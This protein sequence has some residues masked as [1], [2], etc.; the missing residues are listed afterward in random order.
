MAFLDPVFNPVL[1]PLLNVSP[2]LVIVLVSLL[3]SL[4][5]TF[6]YKWMTN[7]DEMKRLKEQQKEYQ[8]RMK[9]LRS[10]PDEMMKVQKEAM[11]ANMD[12]MK[13]SFKPT[14]V[15]MLPIIL[16][17]TW[18]AG[19]LSYEPVYPGETYS[20]TATF[21]KGVTGTAE[22][23]ADVGTEL[24]SEAK[25]QVN[26]GEVTW[27]MKSAEGEHTLT[28]K[29]GETQQQKKVLITKDLKYES[30]LSEFK[31]SAI[32]K[33]TINYNKL[34]PLGQLSL[35]GWQPGWLGI[36][37]IFSIVFSLGLRKLLKIY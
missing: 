13:Q 26:N 27:R 2:A 15:T 36:Y 32:E 3:V 25:Q 8:K 30:Q 6:V 23:V 17:F 12:Y 9:G 35:F 21:A 18:M 20:I 4:L 14:L 5:I 10:N 28:V 33:I 22:L 16:I 1:Q 31:N 7:Q 34:R 11:K 29:A 19:H 37:F 24:S